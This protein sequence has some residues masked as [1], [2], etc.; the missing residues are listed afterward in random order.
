[1]NVGTAERWFSLAGGVLLSA[2]GLRR[3]DLLG[4]GCA[5]AGG[6][7]ILRGVT[8]HC[9][10]YEALGV[11]TSEHHSPATSVPATRGIRVVE[12]IDIDRS[13]EEVYRIWHDFEELPRFMKHLKA[14]TVQDHRSHWTAQA[15]AGASV[16]WDAEIINDE[17]YRL[18]AW[19]S[20]PGSQVATA[21]SVHFT[22]SPSGGTRVRVELKYDPPAGKAGSWLAWLFG[23][24][25]S[26]QIR[27]DLQRF[28]QLMEVG[29]VPAEMAHVR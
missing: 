24:E 10:A 15:P 8:G 6:G 7:L 28:K 26:V 17:P 9:S 16:A 5:V 2:Y 23:E 14:V 12:E 1:M 18:I 20:L 19:R 22:R 11:D 21:G 27:N 29:G 3:S 25:P 4:F 13:P